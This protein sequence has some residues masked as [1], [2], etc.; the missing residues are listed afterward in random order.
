LLLSLLQNGIGL[1]IFKRK[2]YVQVARLAKSVQGSIYGDAHVA[3][4]HGGMVSWIST[5][6]KTLGA[7]IHGRL[8]RPSLQ[9]SNNILP[10]S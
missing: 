5:K 8:S 9:L 3:N 6:S 4:R 10:T 1:K 2:S 7:T